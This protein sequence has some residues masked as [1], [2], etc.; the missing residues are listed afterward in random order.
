[1]EVR[2]SLGLARMGLARLTCNLCSVRDMVIPSFGCTFGPSYAASKPLEEI[3]KPC[4]V[5]SDPCNPA[6]RFER[7]VNFSYRIRLSSDI[8]TLD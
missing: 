6:A 5:Y 1:M 8:S 3:P 4:F 2:L 7:G